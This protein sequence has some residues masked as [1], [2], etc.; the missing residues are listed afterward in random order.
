[1]LTGGELPPKLPQPSPP[2]EAPTEEQGSSEDP[3][4]KLPSADEFIASA[5]LPDE[6]VSPNPKPHT[7]APPVHV[8]VECNPS[9]I[10]HIDTSF[11]SGVEHF[12][13]DLR[14]GEA[15][16]LGISF[17][18]YLAVTKFC[19]KFVAP[20][21]QQPFATAFFDGGKIQNRTWGL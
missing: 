14:K 21:Y 7:R 6:A 2:N 1:M 15:A 16:P 20:K 11:H 4:S 10:P 8:P 5:G 12:A 19:Y 18:P 17:S 9:A 13:F 3:I